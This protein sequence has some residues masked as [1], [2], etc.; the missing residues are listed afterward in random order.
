MKKIVV[1]KEIILF[2]FLKLKLNNL[3]KNSI[4]NLLTKKL[5][6]VNNKCIT[7]YD[8]LLNINDI[9]EIK[10][11]ND[12]DIIYE[13]KNIIVVNKPY[14]LL[15]VST[16]KVKVKTLYHMV[17]E[18]VKRVNKNNKI[19]IVH[20]LDKDTSGLVMF[21]KSEKVKDLYQ[22][23]WNNIV[24]KRCYYAIVNGKMKNAEGLIESY[25]KENNNHI[26]YVTKN[27]NEGKLAITEYKVLKEKNNKTLLD[28][29]IKTGRKNQIRVHMKENNTPII[30]DIKYGIKEK[31]K[32][33]YLHAYKLE[34]IDPI[35]KKNIKFET[36]IPNEF[37]ALF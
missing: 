9:V 24:N 7:K 28:I 35:T 20:R 32:R 17:S 13:D 19:F 11:T 22:K 10:N 12:I 3:S 21:A 15:T 8:Y 37:K 29:N 16:E 4:K 33:M 36:D 5:V 23:S 6:Y 26:V 1:E 30:G 14:G 31:S 2:E 25:L 34:L 27:K 18:Y